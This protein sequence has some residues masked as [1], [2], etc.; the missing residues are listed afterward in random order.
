M[1]VRDFLQGFSVGM[2]VTCCVLFIVFKGSNQISDEYVIER[3]KQLN[4]VFQDEDSSFLKQDATKEESTEHQNPTEQN[5]NDSKEDSTVNASEDKE[6]VVQETVTIDITKG[7]TSEDVANML[8]DLGIIDD[9]IKFSYYLHNNGYSLRVN[10]GTF[11]IPSDASYEEIAR[12]ITKS[13]KRLA[14]DIYLC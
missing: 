3:A 6:V 4:M 13:K 11:E 5:T 8:Y 2:I 14:N 10:V 1:R 9:V 12:I 7:M